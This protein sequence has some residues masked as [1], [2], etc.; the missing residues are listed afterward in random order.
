M[1]VV[2]IGSMRVAP[3][4]VEAIRPHLR[5]LVE[6]TRRDDGCLAY[7]VAEDLLDPGL[8]R[9][10]EVWPDQASLDAHGAAPH[11]APWREAAAACGLHDRQFAI[12]DAINPRTF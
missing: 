8:F 7:D 6:T 5:V 1:T 10:S 2:V 3:E 9:V 12:Y 11:I 4:Q